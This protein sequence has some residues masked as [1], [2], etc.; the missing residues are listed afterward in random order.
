MAQRRVGPPPRLVG[1]PGDPGAQSGST[2]RIPG[3][4]DPRLDGAN[5]GQD[6]YGMTGFDGQDLQ[7][8]KKP[9]PPDASNIVETEK[10][11]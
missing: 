10:R 1:H 2:G 11:R 3:T 4:G 6:R 5:S 7:K 9:G 8:P